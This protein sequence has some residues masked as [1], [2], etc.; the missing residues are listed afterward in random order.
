MV[1]LICALCSHAHRSGMQ[2][3]LAAVLL[4][5]LAAPG[6]EAVEGDALIEEVVVTAQFTSER[7]QETPIAITAIRTVKKSFGAGQ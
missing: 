5:T 2:T 1:K 7:L 4:A 6:A 3:G